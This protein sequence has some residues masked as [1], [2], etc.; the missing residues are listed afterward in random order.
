MSKDRKILVNCC[1][2]EIDACYDRIESSRTSEEAKKKYA[3][4]ARKQK[5]MLKD[6]KY[7]GKM[8]RLRK[9]T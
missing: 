4:W 7:R 9:S 8:R 2:D 5:E 6:V 1:L 3:G